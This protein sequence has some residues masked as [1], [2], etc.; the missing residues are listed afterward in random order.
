[1]KDI[2][3]TTL[4]LDMDKLAERQA[5]ELLRKQ[6]QEQNETYSAL[7]ASAINAYYGGQGSDAKSFDENQ[8]DEIRSIVREEMAAVP[9][10][11]GSFFQLLGQAPQ[12]EPIPENNEPD[13]DELDDILES[14]GS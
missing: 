10:S 4:R 11:I 3:R 12:T 8:R 6:R 13:D 2:F 14:F 9:L 1:M 5:T 7:I